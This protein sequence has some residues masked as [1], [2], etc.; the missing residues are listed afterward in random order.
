MVAAAHW[1]PAV[2]PAARPA[3]VISA[4]PLT[5]RPKFG[6]LAFLKTGGALRANGIT[7]GHRITLVC[8]AMIESTNTARIPPA[9][10][11]CGQ[12]APGLTASGG[13]LDPAL[14]SGS[15]TA[16]ADLRFTRGS[17]SLAVSQARV[18]ASR[19]VV[20][21]AVAIRGHEVSLGTVRPR[22]IR[23]VSD[24]TFANR[25]LVLTAPGARA[26]GH[27]LGT[28]LKAGGVI[29]TFGGNIVFTQANVV[30]GTA[31]L[32]LPSQVT[33]APTGAATGGGHAVDLPVL[34]GIVPLSKGLLS[35]NG[36]LHLSG[37]V[38]LTVGGRTVTLTAIGVTPRG[39][40]VVRRTD[41]LIVRVNGHSVK[42]ANM[43]TAGSAASD[44][45]RTESIDES[46]ITLTSAGAKALGA[47]FKTG[48]HFGTAQIAATVGD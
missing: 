30:S 15:V 19:G 17:R 18:T 23:T 29:A 21:V 27:A 34:P 20:T 6:G 44:S 24:V 25:P 40:E 10:E 13:S 1:I 2:A 46:S 16:T 45:G 22:V 26:L 4:R 12:G 3:A 39:N 7:I 41:V 38:S 37:G 9:H 36:T 47:P 43:A 8:G 14:G 28:T 5:V 11:A 33:V 35:L 42:L 32:S 31:T 48:S